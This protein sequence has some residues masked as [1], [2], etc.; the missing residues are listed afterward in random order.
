MILPINHVADWRYIRQHNQTQINKDVIRE[1]TTRIDHDYK[2]E[3]KVITTNRS[4][5]K[6]K[7]LFKGL[8]EIVQMCTNGAITLRTGAATM[9]INIRNINPYKDTDV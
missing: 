3:D 4:A 9:I 6:Y 8:Y 2:V 1:N 5:Y 7:T